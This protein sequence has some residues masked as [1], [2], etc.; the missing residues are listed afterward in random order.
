M[1]VLRFFLVFLYTAV[2]FPFSYFS[3]VTKH[4]VLLVDVLAG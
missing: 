4:L 1:S 3:S 2:L